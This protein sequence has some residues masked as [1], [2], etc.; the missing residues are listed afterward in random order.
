M[1]TIKDLLSSMIG[2]INSKVSTWEELPDKPF[3][4]KTEMVEIVPL[5]T[6]TPVK[7]DWTEDE[8]YYAELET[9]DAWF[10][11]NNGAEYTVT[12]NGKTYNLAEYSDETY[13]DE[14]T[15]GAPYNDFTEYPFSL[16]TAST[17][18]FVY[19]AT[20]EDITIAAST[21]VTKITQIDPKYVPMVVPTIPSVYVGVLKN[22]THIYV[23]STQC[24]YE[25]LMEMFYDYGCFNVIIRFKDNTVTGKP[26]KI[27]TSPLVEIKNDIIYISS[28]D[29]F[30]ITLA[31]GYNYELVE[32][33]PS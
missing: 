28:N 14:P 17:P 13:D 32:N 6:V 12:Y 26:Y 15:V 24:S 9:S 20:A 1:A 23:N 30:N 16:Y 21:E 19:T 29:D 22:S 3:G 31:E 7:A 2:K 5:Q 11:R 8:I 10:N 25:E 27:Y 18:M 33:G 4:T